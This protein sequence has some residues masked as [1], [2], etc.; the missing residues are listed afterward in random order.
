MRLFRY[1]LLFLLCIP[2]TIV[3]GGNDDASDKSKSS[4][5]LMFRGNPQLT[6]VKEGELP[7]NPEPLWTFE[8][9]DAVESTAAIYNGTVYFGTLDGNF[10]AIDFATGKL[11]WKLEGTDPIKSSPSIYNDTVYFGDELGKFYALNAKTG[12][13]I[14][15][16]EAEGEI[17]S[18]AN[19][20]KDKVLFGAYDNFLRFLLL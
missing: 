17:N 8:A 20:Y 5:W 10:Y 11:K 4:N 2:N 6:G 3:I 1:Y 12:E 7:E 19:F 15:T 18:S 16:F 13:K 9:S 14:W